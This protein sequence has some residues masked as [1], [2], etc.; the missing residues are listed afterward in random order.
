[1]T[2]GERIVFY[3]LK[4]KINQKQLAQ[5]LG[6]TPTRLNYWEKDKRQPDVSM[7]KAISDALEVSPDI[8][9]GNAPDES[10]QI[11]KSPEL[12]CSEER[13]SMDESNDLFDILIDGG[14]IDEGVNLTD[15]DRAFLEHIIGL[16]D[17]WC[18][19]KRK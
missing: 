5:I 2:F 10:E 11:K 16:L 17:V 13:I 4:K 18:R 8:L 15:D 3:R 1:M 6:I 7:I 12:E 14:F 9:I 19:S